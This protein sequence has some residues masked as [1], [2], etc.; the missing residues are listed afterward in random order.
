MNTFPR[1]RMLT[2]P[3]KCRLRTGFEGL[4]DGAMSAASE[5]ITG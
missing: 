4:M 1:T 3:V 2:V 5:P